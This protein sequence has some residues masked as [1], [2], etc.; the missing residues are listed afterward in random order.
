[1]SRIVGLCR[2]AALLVDRRQRSE[3][4]ALMPWLIAC[5][6]E[7]NARGW[8]AWLK[9]IFKARNG[10]QTHEPREG[11]FA[12]TT[13]ASPRSDS[14]AQ[15]I[16]RTFSRCDR[17]AHVRLQSRRHQR[18]HPCW[19]LEECDERARLATP[20]PFSVDRLRRRSKG[21]ASEPACDAPGRLRNCCMKKS[22]GTSAAQQPGLEIVGLTLLNRRRRRTE[23]R[24]AAA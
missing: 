4:V 18:C 5:N 10:I 19:I 11:R 23:Q 12:G 20:D 3:R 14:G 2:R 6:V 1:M 21:C 9:S 16:S 17:T 15:R 13:V 22:R 8:S 24:R 7:S